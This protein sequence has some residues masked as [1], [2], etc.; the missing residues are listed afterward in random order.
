MIIQ[1]TI[2]VRPHLKKYIVKKFK[3]QHIIK[4]SHHSIF[5]KLVVKSFSEHFA[6]ARET[7]AFRS[8]IFIE[9]DHE[10][11]LTLSAGNI[12]DFNSLVEDIYR[13]ELIQYVM[14]EK[15]WNPH[16]ERKRS[17]ETFNSYFGITEDDIALETIIKFMQRSA[18]DRHYFDFQN[19]KK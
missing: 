3:A 5:G 4:I 11:E 18:E 17:I 10:F 9:F 7:S 15:L 16:F 19:Y 13:Q 6:R 8:S 1:A 14:H 2:P 12:Y